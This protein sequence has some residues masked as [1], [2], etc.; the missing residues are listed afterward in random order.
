MQYLGIFF[1]LFFLNTDQTLLW[2]SCPDEEGG[3]WNFSPTGVRSECCSVSFPLR[4]VT[5]AAKYK[6]IF[7]EQILRTTILCSSTG[8][9]FE[10]VSTV[11]IFE[12]LYV[13]VG[14]HIFLSCGMMILECFRFCCFVVT[15]LGFS[16]C[17]FV[18]IFPIYFSMIHTLTSIGQVSQVNYNFQSPGLSQCQSWGILM[19]NK[20]VDYDV[21]KRCHGIKR[22]VCFNS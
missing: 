3:A 17:I 14:L 7:W 19:G 2:D 18:N 20:T 10:Y 11:F 9:C 15:D 1:Y 6:S 22:A 16:F 13:Y 5:F 12:V 4:I 8:Q 21:I